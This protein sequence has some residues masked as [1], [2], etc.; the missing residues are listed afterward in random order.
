MSFATPAAGTYTVT[1]DGF[2]S[3]RVTEYDYLDVFFASALGSL[4]VDETPFS[5]AGGATRKIE[6]TITANACPRRAVSCSGSCRWRAP[7]ALSRQ[8]F[9]PDQGS[10]RVVTRDS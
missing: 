9:G 10:H 6:G 3:P 4:A 5:F 7:V 8:G 1:V 2:A